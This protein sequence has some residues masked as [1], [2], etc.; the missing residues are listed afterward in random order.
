MSDAQKLFSI[1]HVGCRLGN[2]KPFLVGAAAVF[3]EQAG[4]LDSQFRELEVPI[5]SVDAAFDGVAQARS[6]HQKYFLLPRTSE[7]RMTLS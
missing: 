1:A 3:L 5:S 2:K 7:L 4:R 6:G